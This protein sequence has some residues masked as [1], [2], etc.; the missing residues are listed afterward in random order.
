LALGKKEKEK[1]I[2]KF[3]IHD[4]DTGSPELQVAI[5][6]K[7][8]EELTKHLKVNKKDH[9]SRR[10]LLKIVGRRRKLLNYIKSRD[11]DRYRK[12]VEKLGIRG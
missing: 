7:R 9:H 3:R 1:I 5:L 8:I 12:L 11:I 6:T 4:K 2:S 10:G